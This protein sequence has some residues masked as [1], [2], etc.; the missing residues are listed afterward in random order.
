MNLTRQTR[1]EAMGFC[2]RVMLAWLTPG[3]GFASSAP[4]WAQTIKHSGHRFKIGVCDWTAGKRADPAALEVAKRLG[5]DGIM[6]LMEYSEAGSPLLRPAMQEQY[7][8][9]ARELQMGIGGLSLGALG[10]V[11]YKSDPRAQQWVADSI[12]VSRGIGT[13]IVLVPF[14]GKAADLKNDQKGTDVVIQR[15][16]EIAPRAEKAGVV[17]GIESWLN[18]DEHMAILDKVGSNAVQVYYDMG[19]SHKMGYDIYKEIRFLGKHICQFHAKDYDGLFGKGTINFP[20]ARK[21]LDDI[22]FSG[23][24][25]IEEGEKPLSE[26]EVG[27]NARYLR[28]VF[29]RDA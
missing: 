9:M 17:L 3:A 5:L 29:P 27:Y 18:A 1:R 8:T 6:P 12:E 23:W 22:G 4:L 11:P 10:Q 25:H 14:F 21:A 7:R 13:Q 24:I 28:S 15:F 19:N 20:E 16:K 26:E 2:A